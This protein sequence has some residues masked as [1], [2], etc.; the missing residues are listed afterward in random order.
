MIRQLQQESCGG[1]YA[2]IHPFSPDWE[3]ICAAYGLPYT[4]P[5]SLPALAEAVR[6]A[7][8]SGQPRM[9]HCVIAE[10]ELVHS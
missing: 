8:A 7:M 4:R 5:D 6:T 9:I 3:G 2:G 1:R 10:E